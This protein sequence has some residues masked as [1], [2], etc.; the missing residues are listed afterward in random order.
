MAAIRPIRQGELSRG[1]RSQAN[2]ER[3]G[4]LSQPDNMEALLAT[5]RFEGGK[6]VEVRIYPADVGI[7]YRPVS[8]IGIPLDPTPEIA[9][10]ILEK[11]QRLS[12][13]FGT[14]MTIENGVGVIRVAAG[15]TLVGRPGSSGG[16][17]PAVRVAGRAR[18]A[19]VPT[20]CKDCRC[21]VDPSRCSRSRSD[22]CCCGPAGASLAYSVN[23]RP[24][25]P[26]PLPAAR[27]V[28]A[29]TCAR[30][31]QAMHDTWQGGRHSKMLQPATRGTRQGRF[32]EQRRS[33]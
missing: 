25:S 5:S 33:R 30:C 18:R 16:P 26:S 2:L 24:I 21:P 31:H 15:Q 28:G 3:P 17:F 7:G 9:R 23:S 27:Y 19:G 4:G 11:V 13:P 8:K 6:L 29:A 10:E 20:R 12:K 32:L 14:N 1:E 22:S